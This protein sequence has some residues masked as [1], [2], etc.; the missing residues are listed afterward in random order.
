MLGLLIIFSLWIALAIIIIIP[1]VLTF[2]LGSYVA[3]K[4]GLEGFN[5]YLFMI[6]FYSIILCIFIII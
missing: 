4:L 1:L 6:I 3:E 5:Y 2:A